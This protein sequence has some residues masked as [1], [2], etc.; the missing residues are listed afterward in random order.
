MI[1]SSTDNSTQSRSSQSWSTQSRSSQSRSSQ[2]RS[3]QSWSTQS[4]STQSRSSQSWS[5]QS[6]STQSRSSQSWSSSE[7]GRRIK[8]SEQVEVE[9]QT[10]SSLLSALSVALL[11]LQRAAVHHS[12]S[13]RNTAGTRRR[14]Q[15]VRPRWG[16]LLDQNPAPRVFTGSWTSLI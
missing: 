7:S 3:S 8:F 16:D 11:H 4:R 5:T 6:S 10:L 12:Y 15:E 9:E 1:F 13:S 2:S 14:H